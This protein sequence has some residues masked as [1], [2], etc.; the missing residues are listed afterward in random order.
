MTWSIPLAVRVCTLSVT[1]D[2]TVVIDSRFSA[3]ASWG[4]SF[5]STKAE[6]Q[7]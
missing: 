7:L 2:D 5:G 3:D 6:L 4:V 1:R